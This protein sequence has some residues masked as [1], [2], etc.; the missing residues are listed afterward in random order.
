MKPLKLLGLITL[1]ALTINQSFAQI[2]VDA[3]QVHE[4]NEGI[5]K[6]KSSSNEERKAAFSQGKSPAKNDKGWQTATTSNGTVNYS[7]KSVLK[8]CQ[9]ELDF[10]YF[11][12]IVTVPSNVKVDRFTISYDKADDGAR[13]FIFNDKHKNGYF[14]PEADLIR[15]VTNYQ[16]VDFKKFISQGENRILIVQYDNCPVEN[17]LQGIRIK[18]NGEEIKAAVA[19]TTTAPAATAAPAS[20]CTV[21]ENSNFGGRSRSFGEG[22]HDINT[23]DFNDIISSIKIATGWKVTLYEHFKFTGRSIVLTADSRDLSSANFSKIASSL[24]V[25][26]TSSTTSGTTSSESFLTAGSSLSANQQIVSAN[27]V[28]NLI[29]QQ[30]GNLCVYKNKTTFVWGSMCHGKS[31][32]RFTFEKNGNLCVYNQSNQ[33]IWSSFTNRVESDKIGTRLV[34]ENDGKLV[35]YNA[36]NKAIWNACNFYL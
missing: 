17:N 15:N 27:G 5:I 18:V 24:K 14:N 21:F 10:T 32:T 8:E 1:S 31:G 4:G 2:K 19:N 30:D 12:S 33:M 16:E 23:T 11:Q 9:G 20:G 36:Q 3:W 6:F 25:E 22:S 35:L 34:I 13:I 7:R 26:R 29:F 28:Y